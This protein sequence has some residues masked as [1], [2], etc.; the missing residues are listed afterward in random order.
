MNST[1]L[2]RNGTPGNVFIS[3]VPLCFSLLAASTPDLKGSLA[4]EIVERALKAA[5]R[6]M[7]NASR[8][9]RET[10]DHAIV[11]HGAEAAEA[12]EFGGL[13]L[14]EAAA[15]CGDDV[16]RIARLSADAPLAVA[17]RPESLVA[18]SKR[19]GDAAALVEI[20]CPGCGEALASRLGKTSMEEIAAKAGE[21][22]IQRLAGLAARQTPA[23][24]DASFKIWKRGGGRALE[25]LTPGRI[26]ASGF[27]TA[28]MI[29]AWKTPAAFLG[30][31]EA[32]LSGL[33]SPVF[34][35]ASWA[36]LLVVFIFLQQPLLWLVRRG[37]TVVRRAYQAARRI[38]AEQA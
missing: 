12:A 4:G 7:D 14:M 31:V 24:L 37:A 11:K 38:S 8:A 18:I 32:A 13:P 35:V 26:A 9:T 20:K 15:R 27:A 34:T 17:A 3:I 22:E 30:L 2:G 23:E 10:L 6:T 33:L 21:R 5:G 25:F 36:L 29:T 16:W 19:W 1:S 28:A